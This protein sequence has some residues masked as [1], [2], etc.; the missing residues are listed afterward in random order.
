MSDIGLRFVSALGLVA[1]I[2]IAWAFSVDR[3]R[4]PWRTVLF[5]LGIQLGLAL[6]LLRTAAGRTFFA[7]AS[8][9]VG[10]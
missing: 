1:M 7:G 8:A 10:G 2:A 6:L 3:R 5:G 4:M 9:A